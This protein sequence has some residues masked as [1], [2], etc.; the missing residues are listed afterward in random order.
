MIRI[1]L[2]PAKRKKKASEFPIHFIP[3]IF[4]T[5]VAVVLMVVY[6]FYLNNQITTKKA[7]RTA[8]EQRL[9][10][11]KEKIKEVENYEKDNE[12]FREK[13]KVIEEL[14]ARQAAPLILLD[15]VSNM[16][17]KGVWLTAL[18]DSGGTINITGVAF[19]NPDL[20]NYVQNLK[21]SKY[22]TDVQLIESRQTKIEQSSVYNFSL[23]F[24]LKI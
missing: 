1:N 17:P 12:A 24:K 11:I 20:V 23:S 21:G 10:E 15:E 7:E 14:K 5:I 6:Y 9:A 18:T 13:N 3:G 22:M 2:L 8:K 19:T 16:L 4:V